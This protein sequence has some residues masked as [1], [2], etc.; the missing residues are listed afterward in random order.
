MLLLTNGDNVDVSRFDAAFTSW[1]NKPYTFIP[2]SS[3]GVLPI[4]AWP[5]LQELISVGTRLVVFLDYGASPS[6]YP[7]ILDE[8]PYFF[9][10]PY[11]NTDPTFPDCTLDR[12]AA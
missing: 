9:E 7:Y 2:A 5:T 8:F 12:P 4:D 10:T 6:T 3:P 11:D 1:G